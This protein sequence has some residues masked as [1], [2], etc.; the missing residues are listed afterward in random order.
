MHGY[1]GIKNDDQL[2]MAI[3]S[4]KDLQNQLDSLINE[5]KVR[6]NSNPQ[7]TLDDYCKR[8]VNLLNKKLRM[9]GITNK[10]FF[11]DKFVYDDKSRTMQINFSSAA[12]SENDT[13]KHYGAYAINK[14]KTHVSFLP[15]LYNYGWEV[16]RKK[17]AAV[18]KNPALMSFEYYAGSYFITE[19][20]EEFNAQYAN[21]NV[22][23]KFLYGDT[24]L[25]LYMGNGKLPY[26]QS[27]L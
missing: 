25:T 17:T 22:Y 14:Y 3:T 16:K 4:D 9:A 26:I 11:E 7:K 24:N 13:D 15:V 1:T 18:R 8:L 12:Y 20:I 23:A 19:A 10:D 2:F 27:Y 5:G 6:R 21:K